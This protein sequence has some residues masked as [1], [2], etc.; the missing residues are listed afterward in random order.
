[1]NSSLNPLISLPILPSRLG[2]S[3]YFVLRKVYGRRLGVR[4][5]EKA[6]ERERREKKE[7]GK[8]DTK[9]KNTKQSRK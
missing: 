6:T 7:K 4:E 1:M 9:S 2:Q 5:S 8:K 3:H